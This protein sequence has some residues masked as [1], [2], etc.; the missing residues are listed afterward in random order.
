MSVFWCSERTQRFVHW[1]SLH[2]PVDLIG[3]MTE[4]ISNGPNWVEAIPPYVETD[5]IFET[6]DLPGYLMMKKSSN[7]VSKRLIYRWHNLIGHTY[8]QN[9]PLN[10]RGIEFEC[11]CWTLTLPLW[12]H[13]LVAGVTVRILYTSRRRS[14]RNLEIKTQI[15]Y[16]FICY[17]MCTSNCCA[18]KILRIKLSITNRTHNYPV[19]NVLWDVVSLETYWSVL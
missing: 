11:V 8:N 12:V 18:P 15:V 4:I 7:S 10:Q 1:I 3:P 5:Q 2:S 17:N 19:R 13:I 16:L 14:L 9:W 6:C